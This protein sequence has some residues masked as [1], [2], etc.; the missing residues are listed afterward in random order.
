MKFL[1]NNKKA[2]YGG[3]ITFALTGVGVFLLG[4]VSGYEA[5]HLIK[6]SLQGVI[7]LC[8]TIVLASATILA[9]ILTLLGISS[10]V[11]SKLKD[12][13]YKQVIQIA[14]FDTVLFI[15]ALILFEFFNLPITETDNV[16]PNWYRYIYW[17][18]LFFSSLLSG[19]MVSVVLMLYTTVTD[20]ISIVGLGRDHHLVNDEM[21][22]EED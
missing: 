4:N 21:E 6:S 5:K 11:E 18:S 16:P 17:T 15:S 12:Q 14:K 7:M 22:E 20:I 1:V 9:L 8:N 19:Y 10:G 3:I 13:H 2:I